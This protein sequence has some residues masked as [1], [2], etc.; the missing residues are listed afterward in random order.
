MVSTETREDLSA[1]D[2]FDPALVERPFAYYRA[3]RREAP[4]YR[5]PKSG[6]FMVSTY[7][8]VVEALRRHDD[9]S[10]AFGPALQG[11]GGP[12][13]EV[14]AILR[15]GYPVVDTMLTCDP[16]AHHR[17]RALV[18]KAFSAKRIAKMEPFIQKVASDLADTFVARGSCELVREFCV[19]FPLTVI[20]HQLGVPTADLPRFKRWSDAFLTQL[21]QMADLDRQLEAARLVVEFQRYFAAKIDEK[22]AC[23]SEDILSDLV[24]AEVEGH[25]PLDLPELLSIIQQILVAGNETTA[26][27][28]AEGVLMLVELP[29]LRAR[30]MREPALLPNICEEILRLSTPTSSMWRVATR[31]VE[32]GGVRIP[33][34]STLLVRF[35][36]ANRDDAHF[37]YPE[38]LDP[39]RKNAHTHLAF[40][41]GIHH[42]LGAPLA[43]VELLVALRLLLSRLCNI[44]L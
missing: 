12:R 13:P 6:I 10:S 26:S 27:A 16:P 36:A 41:G 4:V 22:R 24:T 43:R 11:R 1:Y 25:R 8:L 44:R 17:Y 3:L 40:G 29:T 37:D 34:G 20:A 14:A 30:V 2:P 19:P 9:F 15:E 39:E 7:A 5:D 28:I 35:A 38:E 42:C 18:S 31:D 23:P 21:G 33:E 32:L